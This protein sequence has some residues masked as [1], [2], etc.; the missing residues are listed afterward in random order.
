RQTVVATHRGRLVGV[1]GPVEG[2]EQ[3]VAGPVTGEDAAGPVPTVRRRREPDDEQARGRIAEAGH[4]PA[5]VLLVPICSPSLASDLLAPRDQPWAR[6]AFDDLLGQGRE[7]SG[8]PT[9]HH[10][11]DRKG[12]PA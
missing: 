9:S 8:P 1:S 5:P 10:E 7:V 12:F 11:P 6:P 4:R 3:P 2:A